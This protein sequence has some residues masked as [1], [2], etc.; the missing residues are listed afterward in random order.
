MYIY[1]Y[2]FYLYI[3]FIILRVFYCCLIISLFLLQF[4]NEK[5][6]LHT[7][8]SKM[9][10][11]NASV[12]SWLTRQEMKMAKANEQRRL[13]D[14]AAETSALAAQEAVKSTAEIASHTSGTTTISRQIDTSVQSDDLHVDHELHKQLKNEVG[15]MYSAWDEADLRYVYIYPLI[16]CNVQIIHALLNR[17]LR[18]MLMMTLIYRPFVCESVSSRPGNCKPNKRSPDEL[19][20]LSVC[21]FHMLFSTYA[22]THTYITHNLF[23][24]CV[25]KKGSVDLSQSGNRKQ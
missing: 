2:F 21:V 9:L 20:L 7:H 16:S 13:D 18:A 23:D 17:S 1:I 8:R 19:R 22:H 5:T 3:I 12:H 25:C 24:P 10:R 14:A 15:D 4:Q 6:Q 11:L